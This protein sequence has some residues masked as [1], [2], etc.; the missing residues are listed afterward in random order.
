MILINGK[1]K[2]LGRLCTEVAEKLLKQNDKIVIVNSKDVII[3][4]NPTL[5]VKEYLERLDRGGK[6]N[7]ENNPKYPR[8]PHTIVKRAVR[9]MLPR[10]PKGVNA[11]KKLTTHIAVPLEYKDLLPKP[12][13]LKNVSHIALEELSIKL[14]A[15]IKKIETD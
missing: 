1:N 14:G 10:N 11:L 3:S 5:I 6:G 13:T 12:E 8:Y 2:I 4:G 7:P 9:G 15:K